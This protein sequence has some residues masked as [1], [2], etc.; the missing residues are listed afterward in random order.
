[1]ST[2][3]NNEPK[4]QVGNETTLMDDTVAVFDSTT[5]LMAGANPPTT[6]TNEV[7]TS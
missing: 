3:W 4:R 5:V 1:M 2:S 7:K 6:W